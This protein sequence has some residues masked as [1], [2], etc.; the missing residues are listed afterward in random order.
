MASM[1]GLVTLEEEEESPE[2]ACLLP[3]AMCASQLSITVTNTYNNQL[4]KREDLFWLL[5]SV[6][7]AW[8]LW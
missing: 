1:M 2:L 4:I 8:C 3:F 6:P 5:V 7:N